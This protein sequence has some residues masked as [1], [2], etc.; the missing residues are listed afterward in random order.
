MINKKGITIMII[1]IALLAA[2]VLGIVFSNLT[3]KPAE[4]AAAS[5]TYIQNITTEG[6]QSNC[7]T[8]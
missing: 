2:V 1:I 4:P 3:Q 5:G 6:E 7:C 8:N